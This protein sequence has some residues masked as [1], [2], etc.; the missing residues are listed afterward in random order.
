MFSKPISDS[1]KRQHASI[2][3]VLESKGQIER[4]DGN[5]VLH[6]TLLE[7]LKLEIGNPNTRKNYLGAVLRAATTTPPEELK[8]YVE[9]YKTTTSWLKR[10]SISQTLPAHRVEKMLSWSSVLGLK[11]KA[12]T[13]LV[14][15]DYLI[16]CLYTMNPPVRADYANMEVIKSWSKT[17][18]EDTTRNYLLLHGKSGEFIF[19]VYKDSVN[20]GQVRVKLSPALF[21]VVKSHARVGTPLLPSITTPTMLSKRVIQIMEKLSGKQMG[22]GLLRHSYITSYLSSDHPVRIVEKMETARKMMHSY[23]QQEQYHVIES[24]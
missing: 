23:V 15:E 7:F 18:R 16:Y 1:T 5:I 12:E 3:A 4:V 6:K 17:R 10:Q 8:P 13:E 9:L 24:D 19:N 11:A 14:P 21:A 20:K 2:L 22:I